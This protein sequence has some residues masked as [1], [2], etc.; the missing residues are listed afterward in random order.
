MFALKEFLS[1]LV[2]LIL[3]IVNTAISNSYINNVLFTL[4][5]VLTYITCTN[6]WLSLLGVVILGL[7][8]D[9][10]NNISIGISS[11]ILIAISL[12]YLLESKISAS[13]FIKYILGFINLIIL[14]CYIKV[15]GIFINVPFINLVTF[16]IIAVVTFVILLPV[17]LLINKILANVK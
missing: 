15:I 7:I 13:F 8:F 4:F 10:V 2:I 14:I 16:Y 12:I 17:I 3:I 11:S 5:Y 9:S 1:W 6:R